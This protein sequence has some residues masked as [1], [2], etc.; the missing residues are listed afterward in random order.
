M[1]PEQKMMA[2][3]CRRDPASW[4]S[5]HDGESSKAAARRMRLAAVACL[6]C[7]VLLAC[8][9]WLA[10]QESAGIRIDGIVAGRHWH[11][12]DRALVVGDCLD[13]DQPMSKATASL[14]DRLGSGGMMLVRHKGRG[15]CSRCWRARK[16]AGTLDQLPRT[17]NP[18][19]GSA[20]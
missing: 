3:P 4:G 12:R 16:I 5:I 17:R 18:K 19:Q 9:R 6:R 1:T 7:P 20:A 8:R 14:E 13:C 10:D 15:L 11:G 2:A